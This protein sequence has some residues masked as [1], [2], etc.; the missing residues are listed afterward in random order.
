MNIKGLTPG[1]PV[2]NL[3]ESSRW[4]RL[5]L[6]ER[7]EFSPDAS[8]REFLLAKESWLQLIETEDVSSSKNILRLEVED[9]D[10]T[11][12]HVRAMDIELGE[13]IR[14]PDLIALF[15]FKDIDGNNLSFYELASNAT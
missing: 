3:E 10:A 1:I 5:L 13:I 9:I 12:Q 2:S 14:V 11:H 8:N 4:Y 7:E 15:E 6:G